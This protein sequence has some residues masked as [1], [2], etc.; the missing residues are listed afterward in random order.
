MSYPFY[1]YN[2]KKCHGYFFNDKD[3]LYHKCD[4]IIIKNYVTKLAT[5]PQIIYQDIRCLLDV[6]NDKIPIGDDL[7]YIPSTKEYRKRDSND[8]FTYS[9]EPL[10]GGQG[11]NDYLRTIIP[12]SEELYKLQLF[13]FLSMTSYNNGLV[14]IVNGDVDTLFNLLSQL[15]PLIKLGHPSLYCE[16]YAS[17]TNLESVSQARVVLC[18]IN[19]RTLRLAEPIKSYNFPIQYHG[20]VY[21]TNKIKPII[22]VVKTD[23]NRLFKKEQI[24]DWILSL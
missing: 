22:N 20:I 7:I 14:I 21:Q 6:A 5:A 24:L 12:N 11:V 2:S 18:N 17:K 13:L 4:K 19:D 9:F 23:I 8:Y 10:S 16:S 15:D 3:K 1:I